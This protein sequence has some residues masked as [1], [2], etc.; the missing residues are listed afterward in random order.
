VAPTAEV[1][2]SFAVTTG[3]HL[4]ATVGGTG[5]ESSSYR[6][7]PPNNTVDP[8]CGFSGAGCHGQHSFS[9]A[10][11]LTV[12]TAGTQRPGVLKYSLVPFDTH[13]GCC[14][15]GSIT[16]SPNFSP[17]F[18]K[19]I[20]WELGTPF[21]FSYLVTGGGSG[22]GQG[23][24]RLIYDFRFFEAD[25]VTP[26]NVFV[27]PEPATLSMGLVGLAA[28]GTCCRRRIRLTNSLP[29]TSLGRI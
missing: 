9:I 18:Q 13:P 16:Y 12:L 19:T 29:R 17:T 26:V 24:T 5:F 27:V 2:L 4:S 25:G 7:I 23:D 3:D 15:S 11:S 14:S 22:D 6:F 8:I 20:P 10:D 1:M 28:F 21:V